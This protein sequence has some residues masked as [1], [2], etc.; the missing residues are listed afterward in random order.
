MQSP[1]QVSFAGN[2][3]VWPDMASRKVI[4][5]DDPARL[6]IAVTPSGN[7]CTPGPMMLAVRIDV[8][9]VRT[10]V[11]ETT[12]QAFI[13]AAQVLAAAYGKGQ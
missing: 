4:H 11:I 2:G 12:V 7:A 6:Q 8:D 9:D 3:K 1:M 13:Q 5:I 10:L